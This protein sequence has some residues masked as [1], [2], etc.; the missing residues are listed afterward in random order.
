MTYSSDRLDQIETILAAIAQRQ[1]ETAAAIA[2]LEGQQAETAQQQAANT[3]AIAAL[4]RRQ[5]N[6][7]QQQE[8]NMQA[9]AALIEQDLESHQRH[10]REM[11]EI[12][13]GL[14][15]LIQ[16]TEAWTDKAWTNSDRISILETR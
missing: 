8:I 12:R 7:A 13:N 2:A 15:R 5:A 4:E 11:V 9:I 14:A 1:Q 6:M 16:A 10:D 3:E